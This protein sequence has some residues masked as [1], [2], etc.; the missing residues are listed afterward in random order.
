MADF[1]YR[2][3]F[4]PMCLYRLPHHTGLPR[5]I[6]KWCRIAPIIHIIADPL[7]WMWL[8]SQETLPSTNSTSER[9]LVLS[10]S[11]SISLFIYCVLSLEPFERFTKF[12]MFWVRL[13]TTNTVR[14]LIKPDQNRTKNGG[15]MVQI[16]NNHQSPVLYDSSLRLNGRRTYVISIHFACHKKTVLMQGHR[17]QFI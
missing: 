7:Y 3:T 1:W 4:G 10:D 6:V 14:D 16:V 17:Q 11:W 5:C 15:D 9:Q 12:K 8:T 13:I 2:P